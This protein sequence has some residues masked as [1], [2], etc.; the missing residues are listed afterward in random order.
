MESTASEPKVRQVS[1]QELLSLIRTVPLLA[2]LSSEDIA[3]L[4]PVELIDASAGTVLFRQGESVPAF[5][6]ILAGEIR[7]VR[8]DPN[9][10][11]TLLGVYRPGDSF[12]ESPLLLGAS[13]S[14]A[15][16]QAAGDVQL[17]RIEA[18]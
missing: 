12:G 14:A 6:V 17:L 15:E 5:C 10:L 16:C 18:E 9:G 2:R 11:E 7:A 3:C 8:K 13:V 4:G 1:E